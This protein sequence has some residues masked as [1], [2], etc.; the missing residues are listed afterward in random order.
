MAEP[1]NPPL[2]RV[3]LFLKKQDRVSDEFFHNYWKDNHVKVALSNQKFRER[4]V[5]YNQFH[6]SPKLREAAKGFKIPVPDYDGIAEVWVKDLETWIGIASDL[7]FQA[8]IKPDEDH[9]IQAP[10][11]IMLGY[12][13]TVIGESIRAKE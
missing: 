1:E 3:Q 2:I 9:F 10:I 13:N 6:T 11:E 7:D 8:A 4:V 12:D 5:R